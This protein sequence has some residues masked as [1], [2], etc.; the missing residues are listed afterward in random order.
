MKINIEKI[1]E[2]INFLNYHT[3]L[4][5]RSAEVITDKEWDEKYFELKELEEKTGLIYPDSPT[6]SIYFEKVSK[7]KKVKHNHLMLSLNKTKNIEDIKSFVNGHKWIAMAKL[8]GLTCSLKYVNGELVSAETRGNGVEGE[9]VTHN[10]KVISSIPQKINYEN[11]NEIIVD[12]E[13]ICTYENFAEFQTLYK[14]P[15][16]FASG[17]IR[18]LD[19]K[20]CKKR[21]LTFIAWDTIIKNTYYNIEHFNHYNIDNFLSAKLDFLNELGFITVPA[22]LDEY[23]EIDKVID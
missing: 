3:Y 22:F 6:Q 15:R 12:G 13:I 8:D 23:I 9:D 20:E 5:D 18:L 21:N 7:L 10:A 11:R 19:S 17:S 16:N 2:L 4:Y 1:K 14:N